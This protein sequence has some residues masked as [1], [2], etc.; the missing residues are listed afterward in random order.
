MNFKKGDYVS[1]YNPSDPEHNG[2]R[3]FIKSEK[4]LDSYLVTLEN[5]D[6]ISIKRN[7]LRKD[8][9]YYKNGF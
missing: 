5:G 9:P 7:H 8:N 2:Q 1:I 6:I 3:G 4:G